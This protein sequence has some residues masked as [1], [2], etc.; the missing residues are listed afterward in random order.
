MTNTTLI[1]ALVPLVLINLGLDV[2]AL[3]DLARRDKRYVQ[4]QNKWIWAIVI[5]LFS[6]IGPLIYLAAGRTQGSEE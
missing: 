1:L 6:T 5:L 2:F 3:V 4:G